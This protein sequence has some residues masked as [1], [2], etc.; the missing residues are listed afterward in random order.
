[1][2]IHCP[3]KVTPLNWL[4]QQN[5]HSWFFFASV[6]VQRI[7]YIWFKLNNGK[8]KKQFKTPSSEAVA[9]AVWKENW[10]PGATNTPCLLTTTASPWRMS[11]SCL[12]HLKSGKFWQTPLCQALCV[13]VSREAA[14]CSGMERALCSRHEIPHGPELGVDAQEGCRRKEKVAEKFSLFF[15]KCWLWNMRPQ[16]PPC[17]GAEGHALKGLIHAEDPQSIVPTLPSYSLE[18]RRE[19]KYRLMLSCVSYFRQIWQSSVSQEPKRR[20][21]FTN[22]SGWAPT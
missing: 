1:M 18:K 13:L 10:S 14:G 2:T 4:L 15:S 8:R 20:I 7:L 9:I 17:E 16:V 11:R 3:G 22:K 12:K 21:H 19:E 6:A 5:F